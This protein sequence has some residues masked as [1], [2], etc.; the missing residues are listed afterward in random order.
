MSSQVQFKTEFLSFLS[1]SQTTFEI[2]NRHKS[3][4]EILCVIFAILSLSRDAVS[5][6]PVTSPP[7]TQLFGCVTQGMATDVMRCIRQRALAWRLG[8]AG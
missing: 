5:L 4:H 7:L 3:R 2:Q 1:D 8:S 6:Q